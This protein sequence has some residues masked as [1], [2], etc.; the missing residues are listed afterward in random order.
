L[1]T[2]LGTLLANDQDGSNGFEA[3]VSSLSQV[4]DRQP[5][6]WFDLN[7]SITLF[8]EDPRVKAIGPY[9]VTKN[10]FNQ[11]QGKTGLGDLVGDLL[12]GQVTRER[13]LRLGSGLTAGSGASGATGPHDTVPIAQTLVSL[14]NSGSFDSLLHFIFGNLLPSSL[15]SGGWVSAP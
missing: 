14:I 8:E 11:I 6:E 3:W 12:V 4:Y 7:K 13:V 5:T 2:T 1:R 15:T 9:Q 10:V